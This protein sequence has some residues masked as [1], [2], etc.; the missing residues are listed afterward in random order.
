MSRQLGGA[1]GLAG[2]GTVSA[3]GSAR[4]PKVVPKG[5][6]TRTRTGIDSPA[7]V[8][9]WRP[10]PAWSIVSVP[11][12]F[13]VYASGSA[14]ADRGVVV[15]GSHSKYGSTSPWRATIQ[16]RITR[17]ARVPIQERAG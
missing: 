17:P 6:G 9:T 10:T 13:A 4:S 3:V 7:L 11:S 12:S 1:D 16:A 2:R 8:K 5:Y 14:S 15:H